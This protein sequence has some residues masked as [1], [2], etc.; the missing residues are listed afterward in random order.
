[1]T[2]YSG[3]SVMFSANSAIVA[4]EMKS[5]YLRPGVITL[6]GSFAGFSAIAS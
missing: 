6:V 3:S 2:F 5:D 1:M 4:S